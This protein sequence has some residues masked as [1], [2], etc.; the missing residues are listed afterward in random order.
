MPD[1]HR[2][3]KGIPAAA[4]SALFLG[5]TPILGKLAIVAGL[6][7]LIVVA[8][9]TIGAALLML[10]VLAAFQR[11]RFYIY[12]LGL[13][14]CALAG[15]INGIGSLLFYAALG[16]I[17]ASLGQLLY[18]LYPTF[19]ALILY[20]DGYRYNRMTL[21]RLGLTLPAVILLTS[22][23][24]NGGDWTG[25]L[26]MI[27]A[28]A[29][30]ALHIPINQRVLYEA[31]AP[32]VTFYTLIAMTAITVPAAFFFS[33]H[34]MV[35]NWSSLGPLLALTLVTFASRLT[36]FTGVKS[37]GGLDT[38]LLGLGELIVALILAVAWLGERLS[39][40]QWVGAG[41]LAGSLLLIAFDRRQRVSPPMGGWLRWLMPPSAYLKE[42]NIV[43]P[44]APPLEESQRSGADTP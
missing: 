28:A 42:P 14:G 22:P 5:L 18:S 30:Y 33:P 4:A 34:T 43:E 6:P 21:A 31:P 15:V 39:A 2:L 19:V 25:M 16:R 12:P 1:L 17:D 44:A 37:I 38:A 27:G 10:L 26:M 7:P 11:D 32:T 29:L 23:A 3:A 41:L 24:S 40:W 20:V 8:A 13:V 36:L 35:I 9:R